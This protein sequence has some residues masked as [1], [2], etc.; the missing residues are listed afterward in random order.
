MPQNR[1]HLR[2]IVLLLALILP[3]SGAA[4][5]DGRDD[6]RTPTV[7]KGGEVHT[8]SGEVIEGGTVVLG[9]DG[10]IAAVGG[11]GLQIPEFDEEPTVV[12]AAGKVVTPGLVDANTRLGLVEIWAVNR[13]RNHRR[14][15]GSHFRA[16]FR[17][18]D[19]FDPGSTLLPVTRSQG[20]TSSVIV[21]GGGTVPG[22]SAWVDLRGE[23]ADEKVG[24]G[25]VTG[26]S[27]AMNIS[28]G[29]RGGGGLRSR[30]A[31][32]EIL[33]ELYDDVNYYAE[34]REAYD[35]N[36][37]R[38][39]AASRLDLEALVPTT[40]GSL[41]VVFRVNRADAILQALDF[42]GA[43]GID[44]VIVG[45]AEA[46]KVAERLAKEKVPVVVDP[47]QNLPSR[48]ASLGARLDN[49]ALL[50]EAGVPVILS[51]FGAHNVR[52]LRQKA[53][54]AVRAGM[55]HEKALEAVTLRPARAFGMEAA[56]GS[57]EA[58]KRANVVV[59]SGDP[60]ELS[61]KV[62]AMFIGGRP[63]SLENRQNALFERYRELERRKPVKSK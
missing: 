10:T 14:G 6:A 34:N 42:A 20:V 47:V 60:F 54:N 52:K 43:Q 55:S 2:A 36:R 39:L 62:E 61:T 24:Y 32:L 12:D 35:A 15:G 9:P 27:V 41:P 40:D 19:G 50:E 29:P 31:V 45:G 49:A 57:L 63:V 17:T 33:R 5:S 37:A 59:W 22:Q 44:P 58:G 51:T 21:P 46:W 8:V 13:T 1:P 53:G 38:D 26:E 11:A 4:Q 3:A 25:Q 18:A 48:F 7:I 16:A 56:Y 23:R 28:L 30:G